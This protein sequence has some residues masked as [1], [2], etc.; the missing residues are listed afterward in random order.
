MQPAEAHA[1]CRVRR[2][3]TEQNGCL[4]PVFYAERIALVDQ[5]IATNDLAVDRSKAIRLLVELELK[6]KK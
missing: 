5:W 6:V 1:A 4:D 2:F 3:Q